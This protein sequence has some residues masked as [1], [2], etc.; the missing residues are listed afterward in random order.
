MSKDESSFKEQLRHSLRPID[1]VQQTKDHKKLMKEHSMN[2]EPVKRDEQ[3][4]QINLRSVVVMD[5]EPSF[6]L[7]AF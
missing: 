3:V 5:N 2:L 6:F 7:E 1:Q 4:T